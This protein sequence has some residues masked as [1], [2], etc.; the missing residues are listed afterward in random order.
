ML[1]SGCFHLSLLVRAIHGSRIAGFWVVA[2]CSYSA[3][4]FEDRKQVQGRACTVYGS[5]QIEMGWDDS[6]RR[7]QS[8]DGGRNR[9]S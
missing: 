5:T 9:P 8:G 1:D 2:V 4:R 7:A 3:D 6:S